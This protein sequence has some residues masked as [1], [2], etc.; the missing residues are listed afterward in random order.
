VKGVI[1]MLNAIET[2]SLCKDFGNFHAVTDASIKVR[3]RSI[4]GF[5]G[6]N[7]AGK[8]TVM[9]M[10]TGLMKPSRGHIL[11]LDE[12]P[13]GKTSRTGFLPQNMRFDENETARST[14]AFFASIKKVDIKDTLEFAKMLEL[15]LDRKV[16]DLSP[17]NQRKLQLAVVTSGS[18]ELLIFDE[19]TAG[20]DPTGVQQMREIIRLLNS[21]GCTVFVSSHIL[22]ELDDLCDQVIIIDKGKILYQG[23]CS[24]CYEFETGGMP[25]SICAELKDKVNA[26]SVLNGNLLSTEIEKNAV[27]DV[28]KFLCSKNVPVYEVR[29]SG[30][31]A[32]YNRYV[33]EAVQ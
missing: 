31:E 26:R 17:G 33:G 5:I 14:L 15:D 10:L 13:G 24:L 9:R 20:L 16:K 29:R 6:K 32:L 23:A 7:G 18:P 22:R 3:S 27:P 30:F 12:K 2:Q 21:R 19:P 1:F 8:T 11:M 28:L 25:E 4:C